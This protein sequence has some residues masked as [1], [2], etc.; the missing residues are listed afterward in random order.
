MKRQETFLLSALALPEDWRL[1]RTSKPTPVLFAYFSAR[2]SA[3]ALVLMATLEKTGPI[4]KC[5]VLVLILCLFWV[6]ASAASSYLLLKR[7]HAVLFQNRTVCHLFTFLWLA[8]VGTSMTVLPGP[9]HDYYEIANTR[10]CINQKMK[11]Y[12]SSAFMVPVFFDALVFLAVTYKI[13]VFHPTA[14]PKGW[15]AFCCGE[16]LPRLS[17]AILQGGQ[18]YYL[19]T[20]GVNLTRCVLAILP[21][22]SP[23]L[24]LAYSVP[25]VALTSTMAC[26]VFRNLK[27][28]SLQETDVGVLTTIRF[29]D[30][31]PVNIHLPKSRDGASADV[32]LEQAVTV[33]VIDERV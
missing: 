18:Q 10:H 15:K 2:I 27:L 20:T 19:I 28:E 32:D 26:R 21:S 33:T 14:K 24:Q 8:G 6:V 7:V 22:V 23:V 16:A 31:E 12:V 1:I 25:T 4:K 17:R 29:V 5:G 9:L 30:R 3:L 11:S 13:L